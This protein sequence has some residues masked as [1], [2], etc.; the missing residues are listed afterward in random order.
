MKISFA[1]GLSILTFSSLLI[2]VGCQTSGSSE[3]ES[4]EATPSSSAAEGS[5]ESQE[6]TS[7]SHTHESEHDHDHDHSHAHDEETEQIYNGYFED[8]Q[9]KDRSLSDWGG[10]WQSVY[11]YL[12]NGTLDEVFTYKAEHEGDMTAEEYRDYYNEGYQTDADRIVI[13]EDVVTFFKNGEEYSGEYIDDGY[14]ILT[15][16]AGNRGVRYIFKLAEEAEGVPQYIQFSDHSIY[17]TE[18]SHYH[19]YWGDDRESLLDEVTNW[20]TYYPSEM[21]GHDIALEMMA[22]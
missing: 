15:Y 10:D 9:V 7:E 19:L 4:N 22:H 8:S 5:S 11:P 6:Q 21:D 17:P 1:K 13:E 14:E 3:G 2:L 16:D 18:A 12:Q 20:P